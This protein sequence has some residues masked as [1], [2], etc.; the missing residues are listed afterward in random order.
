[1]ASV[2]DRFKY[3]GE[4]SGN[5][6]AWRVVIDLGPSR[7]A[8]AWAWAVAAA[9]L[10][11]AL[12]APLSWP[13]KALL[14]TALAV[15]MVRALRRHGARESPGAIRRLVVDLAGRVEAG[16]AGGD[17]VTGRLAADAFVVPGLTVLRWVPDGARL[18]RAIVVFPDAVDATAYRRLR[19]LLRWR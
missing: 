3:S 12:A 4:A 13:A 16:R 6:P 1:M 9:A 18:S 7:R 11:A 10:A 15:A 8:V 2:R 17:T 5:D 14:A 19:I